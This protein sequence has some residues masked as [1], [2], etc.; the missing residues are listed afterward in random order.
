M[1][2]RLRVLGFGL[3][4]AVVSAYVFASGPKNLSTALGLFLWVWSLSLFIAGPL[5]LLSLVTWFMG[6]R[7]LSEKLFTISVVVLMQFFA[8]FLAQFL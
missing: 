7:L 2:K 5:A 6:K 8:F 3:I 1:K 4:G